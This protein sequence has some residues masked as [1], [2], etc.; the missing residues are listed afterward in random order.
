MNKNLIVNHSTR[1]ACLN[2]LMQ[3]IIIGKSIHFEWLNR[4]LIVFHSS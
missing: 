2:G 1:K 3:L 4:N